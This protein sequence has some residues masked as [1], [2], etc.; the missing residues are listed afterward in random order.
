MSDPSS[1]TLDIL[2][3]P[4]LTDILRP[5]HMYFLYLGELSKFHTS[6][7]RDVQADNCL[8]VTGGLIQSDCFS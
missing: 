7:G 6:S 1:K 5:K 2:S 4:S 8:Q 3:V